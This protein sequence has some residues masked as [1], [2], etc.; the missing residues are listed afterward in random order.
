MLIQRDLE[1]LQLDDFA[2]FVGYAPIE[3]PQLVTV[4]VIEQGG[5]GGVGAAR[6]VRDTFAAAFN[7]RP[8]KLPTRYRTK[9]PVLKDASQL[10][11]GQQLGDPEAPPPPTDT[12]TTTTSAPTTSTTAGTG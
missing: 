4:A 12:S 10:I 6:A 1:L 5:F 7:A 2:W 8:G 9:S 11:N 3:D